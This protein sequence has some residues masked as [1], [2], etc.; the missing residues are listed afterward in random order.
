MS[1]IFAPANANIRISFAPWLRH[2]KALQNAHFYSNL[3][4]KK[5]KSALK[6]KIPHHFSCVVI[7]N[8]YIR[9][10]KETRLKSATRYRQ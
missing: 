3:S 9:Y 8:I 6:I 10:D 4:P 2:R 1:P 7:F 5:E